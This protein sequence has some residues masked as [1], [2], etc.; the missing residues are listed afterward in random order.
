MK[1]YVTMILEKETAKKLRL[2]E[3]GID[4]DYPGFVSS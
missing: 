4:Y 2:K 1:S 3:L